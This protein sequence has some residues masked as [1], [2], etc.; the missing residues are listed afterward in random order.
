MLSGGNVQ[1]SNPDFI[2]LRVIGQVTID[3]IKDDTPTPI[4]SLR[5]FKLDETEGVVA[6]DSGTAETDGV[7]DGTYNT[8][9]QKF[10]ASCLC[11]VAVNTDKLSFEQNFE[12]TQLSDFSFNFWIKTSAISKSIFGY[13]QLSSHRVKAVIDANGKFVFE[14]E[15][16][17]GHNVTLTSTNAVN[18]DEW[19]MI[20]IKH[21]N[22]G[23]TADW[24]LYINGADVKSG[25]AE[26]QNDWTI[27]R[28]IWIGA[29]NHSS[30]GQYC[31]CYIDDVRVFNSAIDVTTITRLLTEA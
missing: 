11:C 12:I 17:S 24:Y 6:I 1:V 15:D 14:T 25:S 18:T 9:V 26:N 27:N 31:D 23:A 2:N 3:I 22:S 29:L 16:A 7:S 4:S 10:G 13:H 30:G 5:W 19:V 20:T 8:E 21:E 28:D